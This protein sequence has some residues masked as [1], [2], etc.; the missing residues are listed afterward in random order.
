[1]KLAAYAHSLKE[2][3]ELKRF[4][5]RYVALHSMLFPGIEGGSLPS[6]DQI[7]TIRSVVKE[8]DLEPTDLVT[9]STWYN[10]G[11]SGYMEQMPS[12]PADPEYEELRKKGVE[13]FK[14]LIRICRDLGCNQIFSLLGGRRLFHY[15][16][17][18]AWRKSVNDLAPTL[19]EE[20]ITLSFIPH[21]GDFME[22]S[23]ACVDMICKTK[24]DQIGY[25]YVV[26]HSFVL[27]GRME[28][29]TSSMIRYAARAGVLKE[30]HMADTLNPAQMWIRDHV[31][32]SPYHCH[33]VPG[34]GVL[35]IKEIVKTLVEMNFEGP[36]LV[37]P[38]RYGISDRSFAEL[39]LESKDVIEGILRDLRNSR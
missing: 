26:P 17:E 32:I 33:L 20:G 11:L 18:D 29:D 6:S 34:K 28:P 35:N 5:F 25:I 9:F 3:G 21:P 31:D 1:M 37:M 2:F 15:D 7:G 14:K 39:S 12:G 22:E 13:Q 38:Y 4:G 30:I 36:V 27:G 23:D 24:C 19:S 16:H 10:L 8:N